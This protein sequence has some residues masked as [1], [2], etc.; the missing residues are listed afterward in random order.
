MYSLLFSF[1]KQLGRAVFN[2]CCLKCALRV[3]IFLAVDV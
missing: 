3:A 1:L 2:R